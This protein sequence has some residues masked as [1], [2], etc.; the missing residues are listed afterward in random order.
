MSRREGKPLKILGAVSAGLLLCVSLSSC[1]ANQAFGID[2]NAP[3]TPE[4]V[5]VL[6]RTAQG[7]DK[8]AQLELGKRFEGG[9]GVP[10]DL[11]RAAKLYAAASSPGDDASIRT[12]YSPSGGVS[13]T[14][15]HG[16]GAGGGL[17][18]AAVRGCALGGSDADRCATLSGADDLL[19][20][21]SYE[22]NFHT[23][24]DKV[25]FS[26]TNGNPHRQLRNCLVEK[27]EAIPCDGA[28]AHPLLRAE[29][30][31]TLD[32]RFAGLAV[33]AQG[34]RDFCGLK[35]TNPG[36]A[37][38]ALAAGESLTPI[39]AVVEAKQNHR[40]PP[41]DFYRADNFMVLMCRLTSRELGLNLSETEKSMCA[42]A[43]PRGDRP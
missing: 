4:E 23:C 9:R 16:G 8:L 10:K 14:V 22:Q 42:I 34:L 19:I 3:S 25:G 11:D 15:L 20:I 12:F 7:G 24:A 43:V 36:G 39:D 33:S 21:I 40:R 6:A 1:A 28:L 13:T 41:S 30:L 32:V 31:A 26:N 27:A 5:K 37:E 2:L 35:P 29:G 18:Y 17:P 38:A